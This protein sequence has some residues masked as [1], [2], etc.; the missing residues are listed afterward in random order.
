MKKVILFLLGFLNLSFSQIIIPDRII[1]TENLITETIN[2]I[3][4]S[5]ND[6]SNSTKNIQ[7]LIA[8]VKGTF[9]MEKMKEFL[10]KEYSPH[11]DI[12]KSILE[13]SI[14]K[15]KLIEGYFPNNKL[16]FNNDG[17]IKANL[18]LK[19][20]K[21][22][23]KSLN[24]PLFIT[25]NPE[26]NLLDDKVSSEKKA[27]KLLFETSGYLGIT[28]KKYFNCNILKSKDFSFRPYFVGNF[29]MLNNPDSLDEGNT[30]D[31]NGLLGIG[32]NGEF[33]VT[34]QSFGRLWFEVSYVYFK[35]NEETIQKIYKNEIKTQ[36]TAITFSVKLDIVDFI[37]FSYQYHKA[38]KSQIKSLDKG[39]NIFTLS[40]SAPLQ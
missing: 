19:S 6:N 38:N 14:E 27:K 11:K 34:G 10:D 4:L 15:A 17:S 40:L 31:Y 3:S 33:N 1:I 39:I 7:K 29:K 25:L 30:I 23:K 28:I 35:G 21:I 2:K 26:F 37:N 20:L 36:F 12:V 8:D 18:N 9:N 32:L 22:A 24:L 5:I 13:H 16:S